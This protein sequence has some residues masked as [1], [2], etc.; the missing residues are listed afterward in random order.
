MI[1]FDFNL[2]FSEAF[3]F[4]ITKLMNKLAAQLKAMVT[5]VTVPLRPEFPIGIFALNG[6]R[7]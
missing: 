2:I 6:F 7:E 5:I 3:F 1:Y 4:Q